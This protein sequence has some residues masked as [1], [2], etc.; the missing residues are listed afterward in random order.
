MAKKRAKRAKKTPQVGLL[1]AKIFGFSFGVICALFVFLLGISAT[2]LNW[3]SSA[4]AVI[5][6]FYLGF[7]ATF[8]GSVVGALWAF[9][10]AFLFFF[11]GVLLYDQVLKAISK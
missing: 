9:V 2:Y 11:L 1:N 5:G 7:D 10:D 3:G 4:V 8:L 6:T